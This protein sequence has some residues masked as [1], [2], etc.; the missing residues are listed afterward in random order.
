MI[1]ESFAEIF[2]GNCGSLGVPAV[3]ASR[4]DLE[5]LVAAVR[6]EP[7]LPVTVDLPS[8]TVSAGSLQIPVSRPEST[9]GALTSGQWDFLGLLVD[10]LPQVHQT[11]TTLPYLHEFAG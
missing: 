3:C 10:G 7:T 9:R 5:R 8:L 2:F 1:A 11:A 4:A 6:A